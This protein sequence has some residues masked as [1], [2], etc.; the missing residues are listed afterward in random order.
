MT[1]SPSQDRLRCVIF[2]EG[3]LSLRCAEIL[4]EKG[5]ELCAVVSPDD[6]VRK[7]SKSHAIPGYESGR[8]L[9][10]GLRGPVDYVFSIV[11]YEILRND[12]LDLPGKST[13][14]YHD[15]PL[16]RYAGMHATSWALM[17]GERLHGITWHLAT[18]VVDGGDILKQAKIEIGRDETAHSLN[19]KCYEAA[20]R[21]FRE[22][23]AELASE[24][25]SCQTQNAAERTFFPRFKRPANAGVI[26]WTSTA[27]RISSL[28]RALD[29]GPHPN[30]LGT[31]KIA[32]GGTF[33]IV[34]EV[35]SVGLEAESSPG[36]INEIGPD[37]LRI[38]TVDDE[39]IVRGFAQ[40][41]GEAVAVADMT[42]AFNLYA[43]YKLPELT[44]D[45][46]SQIEAVLSEV[47]KSEAYWLGKLRQLSLAP[48]AF[49]ESGSMGAAD[50]QEREFLLPSGFLNYIQSS[51]NPTSPA[52]H[53]IAA[54]GGF[55]GRFLDREEFDVGFCDAR[56]RSDVVHKSSTFA[57]RVPFRFE[58]DQ[59]RPFSQLLTSTVAELEGVRRHKTYSRD[60]FARYPELARL[61]RSERCEVFPV[62][63]VVTSGSDSVERAIEGE[64]TFMVDEQACTCR[65]AYDGNT[66][67]KEDVDRLLTYLT[68]FF[69]GVA[70]ESD[71]ALAQIPL[72][73]ESEKDLLLFD[74]NSGR[75]E[76]P[77]DRC[78]HQLFEA[79]VQRTPDKIALIAGDQRLTYK[80]LEQSSNRVAECL[81]DKGVGPDV[82][83][84]ICVER[85]VDMIVGILGILKAGGAY[86]PLDP[87]YPKSRLDQILIDSNA[88]I[89]L[90]QLKIAEKLDATP[91]FVIYMDQ[92]TAPP[93][94]TSRSAFVSAVSPRD[95]A[96]V[97]YTSG[98]TGRP[99]GVAIEHRSTVA[100]LT[101]AI[102]V[103]GPE[104][105]KG[106]VA[107]TS[108]CFDLSIF[109]IFAPLS[110]GGTVILVENILHLPDSPAAAKASLINTVPS[111]IVELLRMNGIPDSVATINL[112]GEPLKTSLVK[113]LYETGTVSEVFDL[114]GPTEDTTYSTF[115]LRNEGKATIG[116]PI[117]NTQAYILDR[118]LQP[119]PP[120]VAGELYL[121]GDGLARGYL[122]QPELT[123]SKFVKN[124]FDPDP[125][126]RM[127]KTG[128]LV[129]YL[130]TFELEY[131]G[132]IDNQVKIRGF[133]IELG[134]IEAVI[135]SHAS[136]QEAV[137]IARDD[138]GRGKRLVAYFVGNG[139]NRI[140]IS[141][142][143]KQV[144]NAL[145]DFMVPSAFVELDEIPLTPNG[146]IDRN[147]LP[148]P[149]GATAEDNLN[150]LPARTNV[151]LKLVHIWERLLKVSPIGIRDD[152]FELGGDSL[153]SVS[154]FVE[155]EEQFGV[156]L[157]LSVLINSP[158]IEK[159]AVELTRGETSKS[160][161]YLVPLQTEGDRAPLFCMHAAGGNVLFYRD[162]SSELGKDQPF[163]GLQARGVADK[164][165]TAHD[166]IEDMAAD[167]LKEIRSLQPEGPYHLCG[168]SFG[169][170]VAFEAARQL[171][172]VGETVS[173][174]ALFDT[175]APGY[176]VQDIQMSHKGR[177]RSFLFRV[178]SLREQ[179][180]EIEN[181]RPRVD[182]VRSKAGKLSKRIRRKIAW[183]K[184][185]F[186]IEYNRATGRELPP[187]MM[188]NH[189]AIRD[190]RDNYMPRKFEG[191][192]L[193]FRAS[194][195]LV[196]NIDQDLGWGR[197]VNGD[198]TAI[199]VK[200]SHG[201]LTVYPFATDLAAKLRP[202]L[203]ERNS[204][205]SAT[206]LTRS[207]AA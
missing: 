171:V 134:E 74:L 47:C 85:S 156:E 143:R 7:W 175:A 112:A 140:T 5:H 100:F 24:S 79:Q 61:G 159:L 29:F 87:A 66:F 37:F 138:G 205:G 132:R 203:E 149:S 76:V 196:P 15:G 94:R 44:R 33:L 198:V 10:A 58:V 146:K 55:L 186:A 53:I 192:L 28:I 8:E 130:P 56:S 165:E 111:A 36:T 160:W 158:T 190:A 172:A 119:V 206:R 97:I 116:R 48:L 166:R 148:A 188:R 154:L 99:K 164:S 108:I 141:D 9:L 179:I 4:I 20:T 65:L 3:T 51:R 191:D 150:Y 89:L 153:V 178:A 52:S 144:K 25:C 197:F 80:D 189:A 101:W 147:S 13:I 38:S 202:V 195:Q 200:G 90:T 168:A 60:M 176:L 81:K 63:V 163:Y 71:R 184:N 142:L 157:P 107:S 18:N 162:L 84:A 41:D 92:G 104:R 136:V 43:G 17:T 1:T 151:E 86:V 106:T 194:E 113:R 54:F 115:T 59:H 73:S 95:L 50:Y 161:K 120:G 177:L 32:I 103:F 180:T 46:I 121:S 173:T 117:S 12:I 91:A 155:V 193:L 49:T 102:S 82:L 77:T 11:N 35:E 62:N 67:A 133:R 129:R 21:T 118:N 31:A 123:A 145:P 174:L 109:E 169:G 204:T 201:A 45:E 70:W 23:I 2:G 127:Y 152:F 183:T 93:L 207:V 96:Y 27:G 40:L 122:N 88:D 30:P 167:Y 181:W 19:T 137:V 98:S 75:V 57:H 83:V 42:A 128:D 187:N 64:I 182:F 110:C 22:L 105:L 124:P 139:K 126:S 26:S 68:I 135:S 6:K 14:N 78:I 199:V 125:G 34:S 72:L 69:E 170:L 16:P 131:L 39:L 114:Y 185:Q